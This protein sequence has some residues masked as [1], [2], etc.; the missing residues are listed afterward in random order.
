MKLLAATILLS[1]TVAAQTVPP[2]RTLATIDSEFRQRQQEIF[3]SGGNR[4]GLSKLATELATELTSFIEHEAEGLD[5]FNARIMLIDVYLNLSKDEEAKQV[6]HSF[7][8]DAAPGFL[9]L[10]A[11]QLA[12]QMGLTKIK[13]TWID[14]AVSKKESLEDQMMMARLLL[15][16]LIE[17]EKG[18]HLIETCRQAATNDEDR[19]HVEWLAA[20]AN[21]D[22]ED[23]PE[24][25]YDK[26]LEALAKTFPNTHWGGIAADRI[27]ARNFKIGS[28]ATPMKMTDTTGKEFGIDHYKG[29]VVLIDFWA[30]WCLPCMRVTPT[31]DQMYEDYHEQGFDIL[32]ISLDENLK[33]MNKAIADKKIRW[34]QV[35]GGNG[36]MSE[37]VLRYNVEAIPHLLLI[38]RDGKIA[39][40]NLFPANPRGIQEMREAIEAALKR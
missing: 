13:Q 2:K 40:M 6:L 30:A 7:D 1:F 35:F 29:R 37:A 28:V 18:E 23:L 10:T 15:T 4:D 33:E 11:A 24:H 38:G 14:T 36:W 34:R 12:G 16:V 5:Q 32:G 20:D 19:A 26:A 27:K 9:L 39:A 25:S 22:R 21:R 3:R 17:T 31:L 8:A